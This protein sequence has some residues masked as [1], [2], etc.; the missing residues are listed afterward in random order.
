MNWAADALFRDALSTS[1]ARELNAM[2]RT[3]LASIATREK[4]NEMENLRRM[5]DEAKQLGEDRRRREIDSR[6]AGDDASVTKFAVED[7]D[8]DDDPDDR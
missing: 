3:A 8:H 4:H 7:A 5:L 6:Y 1:Q 2:C